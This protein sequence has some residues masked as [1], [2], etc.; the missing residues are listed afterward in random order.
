V[1]RDQDTKLT[2]ACAVL[3]VLCL[4]AAVLGLICHELDTTV[5]PL[6]VLAAFA[7]LLM[8]MAPPAVAL[9]ALARRWPSTAIAGVALALVLAV[10]IPLHIGASV[11]PGGTRLEVLQANLRRGSAS[12]QSL[13]DLIRTRHVDI[14]DAEELTTA[15]RDRLVSAGLSRELPYLFDAARPDGANGLAIWSR[16]PLSDEQRYPGFQLGALSAIA[17][18]GPGVTTTVFAVHLAA[19]FPY[20]A[21]L[22]AGE[23]ARLHRILQAIAATGPVIVGGDFNATSDTAQFR[24]LASGSY[25]DAAQQRGAGYLA[26][27]PADR[28]FPPLIGIDHILL[29]RSEAT[30]ITTLR[31]PGSD[32]RALLAGVR[33]G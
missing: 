27:Y 18:I 30:G 3:G 31:L 1:C 28:W 8:F 33:I 19:P 2:I 7:H 4:F 9:F 23:L 26:T 6:V 21:S 14:V 20:V 5:Q 11:A 24:A 12:P 22:W 16:F 15:E 25:R 10:Q 32:H 13:V 29:S 17:T